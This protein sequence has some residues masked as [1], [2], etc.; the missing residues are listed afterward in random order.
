MTQQ[1]HSIP[2]GVN[3]RFF[4]RDHELHFLKTALHP[5][6]DTQLRAV[7]IHGLGG[8][9]KT[10]LALQYANTSLDFYHV[11]A[12]IPAHT[13]SNIVHAISRLAKRL[14]L[15]DEAKGDGNHRH[16]VVKVREWLNITGKPFLLIFDDVN[17]IEHL[18][19]IVSIKSEYLF[20]SLSRLGNS[21]ALEPPDAALPNTHGR[22]T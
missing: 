1:C 6:H 22:Q 13:K 2:Y 14:E 19:Q 12:W 11:I 21:T 8:I 5:Q 10:Q 18:E 16:N 20:F 17:N 7:G 15:A 9:G 4:G 3:L